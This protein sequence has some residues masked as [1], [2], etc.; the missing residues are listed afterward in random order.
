MPC[1]PATFYPLHGPLLPL[2]LHFPAS[3][4]SLPSL[5]QRDKGTDFSS[6]TDDQLRS[7]LDLRGGEHNDCRTQE[8]LVRSWGP[9]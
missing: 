3:C 2:M 8:Q 5:M 7:F 1:T 4:P 9:V 6:W